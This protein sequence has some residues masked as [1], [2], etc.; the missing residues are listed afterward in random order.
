MDRAGWD[1]RGSDA[2]LP[3]AAGRAPRKP[4]SSSQPSPTRP[5]PDS[6]EQQQHVKRPNPRSSSSRRCRKAKNTD[7]PHR[8][9]RGQELERERERRDSS[10]GRSSP[11]LQFTWPTRRVDGYQPR[12]YIRCREHV[13]RW[14]APTTET[15]WPAGPSPARRLRSNRGC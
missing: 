6:P 9:F 4:T 10:D 11:E 15:E 12:S 8:P 3:P 7:T 14:S 5:I 2:V 1:K 13:G